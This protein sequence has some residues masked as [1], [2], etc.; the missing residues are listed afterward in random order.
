MVDGLW[1]RD[2]VSFESV[3]MPGHYLCNMDGTIMVVRGNMGD[4]A[5]RRNCSFK[6]WEN[7]FFD[8]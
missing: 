4:E 6:L 2:T 7:R 3:T 8:G 1:G 5:F